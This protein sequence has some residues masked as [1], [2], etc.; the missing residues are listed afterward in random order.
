MTSCSVRARGRGGGSPD[1]PCYSIL[2][3]AYNF[4]SGV[5][6]TTGGVGIHRGGVREL[7]EEVSE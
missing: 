3:L 5:S 2:S 7:D 6:T 1:T 4:V